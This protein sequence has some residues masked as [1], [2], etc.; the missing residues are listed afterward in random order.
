MRNGDAGFQVRG[1]DI[2]QQ[3]H[4]KPGAQPV[5]QRG[6]FPGRPVGGEHDLLVGLMQGVEGMEKFL[7]SG[8]F[9]RDKLDIIH[10][11]HIC[12]AVFGPEFRRGTGTD[13]LDELVGDVLALG[14]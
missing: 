9:A 11:Q 3:A 8:G 13:G 6:D 4:F 10:Q 1:L 7:L 14:V 2:R 5:F 12:L